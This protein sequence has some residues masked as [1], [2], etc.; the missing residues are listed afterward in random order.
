MYFMVFVAS[1][2]TALVVVAAGA[3]ATSNRGERDGDDGSYGGARGSVY[4]LLRSDDDAV[5]SVLY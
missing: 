5:Y 2:W 4:T 3:P 1:V